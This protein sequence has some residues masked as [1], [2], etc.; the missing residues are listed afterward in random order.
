M[1]RQIE[2]AMRKRRYPGM[3]PEDDWPL[4]RKL[5]PEVGAL[6]YL[7]TFTFFAFLFARWIGEIF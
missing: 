7:V 4:W 6:A 3:F 1:D 2:N 5:I